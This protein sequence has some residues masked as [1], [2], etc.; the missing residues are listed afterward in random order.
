[1][2]VPTSTET[3]GAYSFTVY[4]SS[5]RVQMMIDYGKLRRRVGFVVGA[6][7]GKCGSFGQD[8]HSTG[9]SDSV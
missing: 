1:M 2:P 9:G 4:I 6:G 3:D 7:C 5:C 8:E